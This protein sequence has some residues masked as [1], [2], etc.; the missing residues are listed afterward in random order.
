MRMKTAMFNRT[1]ATVGLMALLWLLCTLTIPGPLQAAVYFDSDFETCNVGTGNDFPCDGWDDFDKEFINEPNHNKIEITNS[2]AITG[3]KSV[4]TTFVNPTV[5]FGSGISCAL[6]NP[7]LYAGIPASDHIF[8]RFAVRRTPDFRIASTNVT[9]LI[10]WPASIGYP[11]I[12]VWMQ[13][14]QYIIAVEGGW[15]TGTVNYVGGGPVSSTAW[16]QVE[17]EFQYN[18]PGQSDGLIRLWVNGVLKIERLNLQ[19]RG[20]TPTSVNGQ[21]LPNPS[22]A[23]FT[24]TQIFV[25]CG[26]GNMWWDRV[27]VGTTRIGPTSAS[28][29][30][31]P[32][33]RPTLNPIP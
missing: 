14:F 24:R 32:P 7:S 23:K 25:Q 15:S 33:A 12:S 29:D 9:K 28:A 22:N 17:T 20:P 11:T 30:S 3:S 19:L 10:R 16:D 18:T 27:A 31:T 1:V 8:T 4:K 5:I 26:L 2:L 13:G 6:D 21:G